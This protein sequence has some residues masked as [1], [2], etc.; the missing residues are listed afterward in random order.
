MIVVGVLV[1]KRGMKSAAD[2]KIETARWNERS[3]RREETETNVQLEFG[4]RKLDLSISTAGQPSDLTRAQS[5]PGRLLDGT[6]Q[7]IAHGPISRTAAS[8]LRPEQGE[9]P[10]HSRTKHSRL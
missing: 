8:M 2:T 7:R 6:N 9:M 10:L 4:D 5:I 3:S 1:W